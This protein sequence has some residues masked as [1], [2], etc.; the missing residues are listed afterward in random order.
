MCGFIYQVN[1]RQM[2]QEVRCRLDVTDVHSP[3]LRAGEMMMAGE[4]MEM[5]FSG[6]GLP[7]NR[8]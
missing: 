5:N 6:I 4:G 2:Q 7:R 3:M 1:G 8:P